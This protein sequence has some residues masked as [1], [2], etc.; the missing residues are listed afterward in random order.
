[1][2][3]IHAK[4]VLDVVYDDAQDDSFD[5]DAQLKFLAR[6]AIDMGMLTSDSPVTVDSY[7]IQT[8][9][10]DIPDTGDLSDG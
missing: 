10:N 9:I 2:A 3:K 7:H 1:M 5:P 4:L 6:M 8:Y